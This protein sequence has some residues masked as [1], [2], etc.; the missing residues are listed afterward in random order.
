MTPSVL[1]PLGDEPSPITAAG[2][3]D[4]SIPRRSASLAPLYGGPGLAGPREDALAAVLKSKPKLL[5]QRGAEDEIGAAGI[6]QEVHRLRSDGQAHDGQRI[7]PD[8]FDHD[9]RL[10]CAL[11]HEPVRREG[12]LSGPGDVER[13]GGDGIAGGEGQCLARQLDGP[14]LLAVIEPGAR[15]TG[16][17]HSVGGVRGNRFFVGA[18]G[19]LRI[20]TLAKAARTGTGIAAGAGLS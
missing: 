13:V 1:K 6:D 18:L 10:I 9:R 20:V 11:D 12:G 3:F 15:K 14:I 2:T 7:G 5:R 4:I 16:E 19:L 8:E 17:R